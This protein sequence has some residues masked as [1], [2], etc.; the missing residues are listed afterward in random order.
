MGRSEIARHSLPA[1]QENAG[2]SSCAFLLG[3]PEGGRAW[4]EGVATGAVLPKL[5][6]TARGPSAGGL[7]GTAAVMESFLRLPHD[8]SLK[9][10]FESLVPAVR[11]LGF[12]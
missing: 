9:P 10:G 4:G 12:P 6:P 3:R 5:A 7:V 11:P 1:P 8:L 2:Q